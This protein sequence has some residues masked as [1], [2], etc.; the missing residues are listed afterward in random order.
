MKKALFLLLCLIAT[1]GISAQDKK[2]EFKSATATSYQ[3][4]EEVS[5]SIDGKTGTIWHSSWYS[6][7]FPVTLTVTLAEESHIDYLRY[8]PRQDGNVNGNWESVTVE[9]TSTTTD[10]N[11]ISIGDYNLNGSGAAHDFY[12]PEGGADCGKIRFTVKSGTNGF[13]SA[14][15]IEAYA[16]DNSKHDA[17]A[18]YFS[19]GLFTELKPGITSSE[20]I[21]DPDARMLVENLLADA[22]KYKKFRVGKYEA[23]LKTSTLRNQLKTSSQYNNYEN[24]TGIYFKP[25]ES[26]IVMASGIG[27]YPVGLTVKNWVKNESSSSYT[28]RNG[29]NYITAATEGNVFVHYYNDEYEKAPDVRLHFVNALVQGYW[30]QETMTNSDWQEL[31]KGRTQKDSTILITRSE[32]AQLAYPVYIW[33]QNCPTDI[34]S[35]MTLYQQVQWAERDILGLERYGRQVKNRQLFYGTTYGFMAAGGEGSYC[36]VNSL[37]A[38]TKPDA[39]DFDFWGV[40]HEWGHNNQ[41][42]PGFKW[43]GC[44]ETT[45]NIYAAWA[46]LHFTGKRH[47]LR[48]EDEYSG[49]GEYSGMRGGRMQTYFEEGIRK[50]NA[51]QLQDGPDYHGETPTAVT[52]NGEDADGKNI[53]SVSTTWRHYDHFVKLVPFWQLTLWGTLAGKC[54]DII[55]MVIEAIR[56]DDNYGSK[57]NTNGKQQINWMKTACDSAR[58]DLLPFFEKAGMLRPIHAYVDDYTKGWNIITEEMIDELKNH[59]KEKGYPAFTEEINYINAHNFDIYRDKRKL[60]TPATLGD[61]CT[62]SNGKVTVQHGI[63]KNAVAFETYRKDGELLRITMYGLGSDD[64]HSYTQV[65]YP[66]DS[67]E[68]LASAYIMAVGYDGTRTRIYENINIQK[69]LEAGKYYSITSVGKGNA[70]SCGASTFTDSN[71]KIT[72]NLSRSTTKSGIK[73]DQIWQWEERNGNFYLYNPQSSHYFGGNANSLTSELC[74]R[75]KAPAWEAA[76]IDEAKGQYILNIKGS[77]NYLNSYSDVNTGLWTGGASDN[78]NIWKIQEITSIKISIPANLYYAACYPFALELPEGVTAYVVGETAT[79][80][81]DDTNYEYAVLDSIAGSIV[82]AY[83]PVIL[84]GA[85]ATYT[86]NIIPGDSTTIETPNLLKGTT[87]K[88]ALTKETFLATI[89]ETSE[90]GTTALIK[91]STTSTQIAVNKSYLMRVELNNAEQLYLGKRSNLTSIDTIGAYENIGTIYTLDGRKAE[92]LEQGRIYITSKGNK[93]F[94]KQTH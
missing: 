6:T 63:V 32:H 31:L 21:E 2:I 1:T 46:Q 60:E 55:P 56:S 87:I 73:A 43:T 57:Y 23:Y 38:I 33:L 78:N 28:L 41:I 47:S 66:G 94:V 18:E 59:V 34:D 54:P 86:C 25:G 71:G 36:N 9:Y 4:G 35:T 49:I 27:D 67:E 68:S 92:R 19:D 52:V 88:R 37:H 42:T 26:Y 48:L 62:Y 10:N 77:G 74:T 17:L 20:G 70:L 39:S 80:T 65:L 81:Y 15:E 85:K 45:N 16:Y 7:T 64:A 91:G 8:I 93:I 89:A 5:K 72:W 83:M 14:A 58:I 76:C 79:E 12:F 51:W 13:A 11:F 3:S 50:G 69:T 40:G 90:A 53:G 84:H 24:P 61:G 22:G 82:P 30:D 29:L 75:T 44:G